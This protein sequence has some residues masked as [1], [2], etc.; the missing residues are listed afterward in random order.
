[1]IY[2]T[3]SIWK[4]NWICVSICFV[5]IFIEFLF[6]NKL[7]DSQTFPHYEFVGWFHVIPKGYMKP[8]KLTLDLHKKISERVDNPSLLIVS[9]EDINEATTRSCSN[10]TDG[11]KIMAD[12]DEDR[13]NANPR[14]GEE[15]IEQEES[16]KIDEI[17]VNADLPLKAY[18]L[19]YKG[20]QVEFMEMPPV[21]IETSEAEKIAVEDIKGTQDGSKQDLANSLSGQKSAIRMFRQR[22][23]IVS[24]YLLSIRA[25][26][27][28]AQNKTFGKE[29]TAVA[30]SKEVAV[31]DYELL[32]KI[33]AFANELSKNR[34]SGFANAAQSQQLDVI[35]A[36]L[37][38]TV[39]K[40]EFTKF[41]SNTIWAAKRSFGPMQ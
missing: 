33:N 28:E 5:Y 15:D 13:L 12:Q 1:M 11:D 24:N 6:S 2:L 29:D 26:Q 30:A 21:V 9:P 7:L 41:D 18:E 31:H 27:Q 20:S 38:S 32:R 4:R 39:M 35:V 40:S 16:D 22:L 37:L 14:E 3:K 23:K 25:A 36:A 10:A 8:L 17:E 34:A 19:I